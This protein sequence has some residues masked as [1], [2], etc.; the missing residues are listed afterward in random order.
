MRVRGF[1]KNMYFVLKNIQNV[2]TSFLLIARILQNN[3]INSIS[4]TTFTTYIQFLY[5]LSR[6]LSKLGRT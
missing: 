4:N 6:D 5:V 1:S 3:Q 2:I